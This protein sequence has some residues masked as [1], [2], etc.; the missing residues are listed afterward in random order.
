MNKKENPKSRGF[1]DSFQSGPPPLSFSLSV[2]CLYVFVQVNIY[3]CAYTYMQLPVTMCEHADAGGHCPFQLYILRLRLLLIL[4]FATVLTR[5][6][7]TRDLPL[8]SSYRHT[9]SHLAFMLM[10]GIQ[11]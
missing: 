3:A 8:N 5:Q 1:Y 6:Q 7:A 10:P 4:E 2:V 9:A 11:I